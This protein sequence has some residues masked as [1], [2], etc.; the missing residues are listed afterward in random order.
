MLET[1]QDDDETRAP[2]RLRALVSWQINKANVVG[3]RL[4]GSRM[5]VTGRS[6][7]AVLAALEEYGALSQADLGR[8]LGLDRNTVNGIATRLDDAGHIV[9][10]T[11]PADRRRNTVAITPSGRRH[12]DDLQA[13]TD[14]IQSDLTAALTGAETKELSRLLAKLLGAH[15]TP[16]A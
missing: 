15:P 5:P 6:D 12:L 4:T 9:R 7:F 11:D 10:S 1:M 3:A 16:T 2:A 14:A 8:R 13:A